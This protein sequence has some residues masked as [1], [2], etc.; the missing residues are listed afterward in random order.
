MEYWNNGILNTYLIYQKLL[1]KIII[2]YLME[3]ND[4]QYKLYYKF[5]ILAASVFHSHL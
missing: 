3:K 2:K 5:Q 1:H 4:D